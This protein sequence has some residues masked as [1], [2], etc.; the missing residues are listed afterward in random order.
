M[1]CACTVHSVSYK[2]QINTNHLQI[3]L[4]HPTTKS[5][6]LQLRRRFGANAFGQ[7]KCLWSTRQLA[8]ECTG[9]NIIFSQI[10]VKIQSQK[11][12]LLLLTS[13]KESFVSSSVSFS[14]FIIRDSSQQ[15]IAGQICAGYEKGKHTYGFLFLVKCQLWWTILKKKPKLFIHE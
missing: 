2:S 12:I 15:L 13:R 6:P 5:K 1:K 3:R 4:H 11:I 10:H 9:E 14:I 7:L 8:Q